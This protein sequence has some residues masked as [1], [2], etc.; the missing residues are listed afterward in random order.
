MPPKQRKRR[1]RGGPAELA[2]APRQ[3]YPFPLNIFFNAKLFYAFFIVVMIASMAAVGFGASQG[4]SSVPP[5]VD[6]PD[7]TPEP[8]PEQQLWPDGAPPVIDTSVEREAVLHTN[9]GEIVIDLAADAPKAVNSFAFLAAKQF[10]NGTAFFFSDEYFAQAGDPTCS[11]DTD[12]LCSGLG[13]PGYTLELE[14]SGLSHTQWTVAAPTIGEGQG[15]V[16]GSQF[17]ILFQDDARLDG[18]DTVFGTVVEGQ[19]ILEGLG[20]YTVCSISTSDECS[21]DLSD[22]LVIERVEIR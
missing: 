9:Q 14:D 18:K 16:H 6:D 17:R 3:K 7:G 12:R 15:Q 13:G 21:E 2:G 11:L 10:Y 5:P 1:R 22:A 4:T 20:S 19:S 8:T